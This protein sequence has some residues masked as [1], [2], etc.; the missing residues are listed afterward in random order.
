MKILKINLM[1]T[2][3]AKEIEINSMNRRTET[4]AMS[5]FIVFNT[6]NN[7]IEHDNILYLNVNSFS[8]SS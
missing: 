2:S 4:L 8:R 1:Q 7:S 6:N 5:L 3:I